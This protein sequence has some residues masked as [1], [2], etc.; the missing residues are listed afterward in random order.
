MET[1]KPRLFEAIKKC[2]CDNCLLV[3]LQ[4]A[5]AGIGMYLLQETIDDQWCQIPVFEGNER[6]YTHLIVKGVL[7]HR[8]TPKETLLA[9]RR[10]NADVKGYTLQ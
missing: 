2:G 1:P 8:Y 9:A 3:C 6:P 4:A 7:A 5:E 10:L